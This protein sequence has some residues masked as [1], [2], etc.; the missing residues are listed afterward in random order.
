[1]NAVSHIFRTPS[2]GIRRGERVVFWFFRA[3]TYFVLLCGAAVFLNIVVKG[4]RTVFKAEAPFINTT[5]LTQAPESLY[6]F[7]WEGKKRE[8]GDREFRA[9]KE[10]N[11]AAAKVES[12]SYV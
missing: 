11:P 1:M 9:V 7:A 10:Q 5:F 12:D 4:S 3:A 2:G 6:I 8:M